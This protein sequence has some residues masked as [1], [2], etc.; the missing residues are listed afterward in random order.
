[1]GHLGALIPGL[2][3]RA[4]RKNSPL[5]HPHQ[6]P[7]QASRLQHAAQAPHDH[8]QPAHEMLT[9]PVTAPA[10]RRII[11]SDT[12]GFVLTP[13]I[14]CVKKTTHPPSHRARGA[15]ECVSGHNR[16]LFTT[17]ARTIGCKMSPFWPQT[18][19]KTRG[20]HPSPRDPLLV[21]PCYLP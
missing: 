4:S 14:L 3:I 20:S 10:Q 17:R 2:F 13:L 6:H 19:D 15:K 5:V 11:R 12:R 18:V 21:H 9:R 16:A 7:Q 1:M 8:A